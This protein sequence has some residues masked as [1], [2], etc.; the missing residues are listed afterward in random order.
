MKSS[1][2]FFSLFLLSFSLFGQHNLSLNYTIRHGNPAILDFRVS[3]IPTE[4]IFFALERGF[5]SKFL[6]ELRVRERVEGF[7]GIFGDKTHHRENVFLLAEYN[8]FNQEFV[9]LTYNGG[10]LSFSGQTIFMATFSR[11]NGVRVHLPQGISPDLLY[12]EAIATLTPI[13]WVMP[14]GIMDFFTNDYKY[15]TPPL[16][17]PLAPP[18]ETVDD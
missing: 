7:W 2:L 10:Q 4:E 8:P 17:I 9:I 18:R 3:A 12:L 16:V 5:Q 13:Q 11:I 14:L 1:F 15:K 6:I